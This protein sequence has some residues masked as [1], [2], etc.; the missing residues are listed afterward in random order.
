MSCRSCITGNQ[1]LGREPRI[2]EGEDEAHRSLKPV[3]LPIKGR[4]L[5]ATKVCDEIEM[6]ESL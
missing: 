2:G 6:E 3:D 4:R 1:E 5:T